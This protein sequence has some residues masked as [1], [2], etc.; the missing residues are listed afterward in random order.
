M[1]HRSLARCWLQLEDEK[2]IRS[3]IALSLGFLPCLSCQTA[4]YSCTTQAGAPGR[5]A[6]GLQASTPTSIPAYTIWGANTGV[7]KTL[8][9]IGLAY[10]ARRNQVSTVALTV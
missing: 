9:S 5:A 7:G 10:A 3:G 6:S 4:R 8:A 1:W 2:G